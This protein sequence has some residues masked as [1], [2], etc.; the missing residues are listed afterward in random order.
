MVVTLYVCVPGLGVYRYHTF[1]QV[2]VGGITHQITDQILRQFFEDNLTRVPGRP[3]HEGKAV[4]TIDLKPEKMYGF[5]E[6]HR[7]VDADIAMSMDGIGL[8]GRQLSIRRPSN[9]TPPP[10][11][12]T[13]KWA[14]PG[15]LSTQV[16]EGP[17]KIFLVCSK[18]TNEQTNEERTCSCSRNAN[19]S[20]SSTNNPSHP[21][22]RNNHNNPNNS[23]R[24]TLVPKYPDT[25]RSITRISLVT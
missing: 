15:A 12:V 1:T 10:N 3:F 11:E 9:Y 24:I 21:S 18:R 8:M 19:S 23:C 4:D 22:L 6:F 14:I 13:K 5:V 17:Y 20:K 7:A 25:M 2:F 16:P